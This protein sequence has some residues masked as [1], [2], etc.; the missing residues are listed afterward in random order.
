MG[1]MRQGPLAESIAKGFAFSTLAFGF[2]L[3]LW[4]FCAELLALRTL[5][6]SFTWLMGA[7]LATGTFALI[8][9]PLSVLL[10]GIRRF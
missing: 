1:K 8:A 10:G 9:L 4:S 3:S 2:I 7:L 6:E 5:A